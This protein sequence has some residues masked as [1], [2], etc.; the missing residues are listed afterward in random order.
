MRVNQSC[1]KQIL[2]L[3]ILLAAASVLCSCNQIINSDKAQTI[4]ETELDVRYGKGNYSLS[5][6]QK[7]KYDPALEYSLVCEALR[8]DVCLNNKD[9]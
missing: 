5:D 8:A 2:V 9:N 4:M 7:G 6:I 3:G 1:R